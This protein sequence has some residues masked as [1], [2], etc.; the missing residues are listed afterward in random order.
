MM[1]TPACRETLGYHE[2]TRTLPISNPYPPQESG[3]ERVWV[4]VLTGS[5]TH[6]EFH[7]KITKITLYYGNYYLLL[8]E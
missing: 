5:K 3:F 6:R 8:V 1:R 7:K 4:R 2:T